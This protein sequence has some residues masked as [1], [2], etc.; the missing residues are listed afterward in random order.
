ML[1]EEKVTSEQSKIEL[2]TETKAAKD[3]TVSVKVKNFGNFFFQ[4]SKI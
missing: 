2:K 3:E 4:F 1:R